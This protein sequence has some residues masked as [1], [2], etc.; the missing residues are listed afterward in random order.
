[1]ACTIAPIIQYDGDAD[2]R[3]TFVL[4][5]NFINRLVV[6]E[7]FVLLLTRIRLE[8]SRVTHHVK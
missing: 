8:L 5:W 7:I 3:S 4:V 2:Y 1:M 6:L